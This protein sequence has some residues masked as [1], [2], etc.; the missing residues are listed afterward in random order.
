MVTTDHF[1]HDS[2]SYGAF[3]PGYPSVLFDYLKSLCA[4]HDQAWDAGCGTGQSAVP[5]A[6]IFERVLATDISENQ[7]HQAPKLPN[8]N[9]QVLLSSKVPLG[10]KSV[11]LVTVA[12]AL[13][14]FELEEFYSEVGRVLK[15]NG[16]IAVWCYGLI[17]FENEAID[18]VV[19]HFYDHTIG[20]YWPPQRHFIDQ[21]YN[22]ISFPFS[23]IETPPFF[24]EWD[25]DRPKF[26]NYLSTW[27]AVK[28]F[29]EENG[30]SPLPALGNQ[31]SKYWPEGESTPYTWPIHLK[32]GRL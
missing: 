32:V 11:D 2:K 31:L 17:R 10:N 5:L 29:I 24:M 19:R 25:F 30:F 23:H 8:I 22:T 12:Q 18:K 13:H 20:H 1:S 28:Y 27:S 15:P 3:R 14:W 4:H 9:Y 21:Q 7:I 26:I 6:A 16:F